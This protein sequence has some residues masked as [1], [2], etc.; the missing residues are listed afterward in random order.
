MASAFGHAAVA[1]A[2]GVLRPRSSRG[3]KFWFW[4]IAGAVIPDLDFVTRYLGVERGTP[5]A[6]RGF[7]HSLLF[8]AVLALLINHLFFG[9]ERRTGGRWDGGRC[10]L[11]FLS[12]ASHSVLDAMTNGG[13]GVAFFWPLTDHRYF[14]PFRPIEVSPLSLPRFFSYRGVEIIQNEIVWIGG[15]CLLFLLG[16]RLARFISGMRRRSPTE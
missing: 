2:L 4:M 7:T 8:A 5:W 14:L 3:A 13:T 11:L 15:G 6:H 1:G 16:I 9:R 12:I 10:L